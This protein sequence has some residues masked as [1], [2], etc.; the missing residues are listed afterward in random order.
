M[1]VAVDD[2]TMEKV[3]SYFFS[4]L[5][6]RMIHDSGSSLRFSKDWCLARFFLV[7]ESFSN[8]S[9][10]QV[11]VNFIGCHGTRGTCSNV[12]TVLCLKASI[13]DIIS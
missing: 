10:D 6:I 13:Y 7:K 2:L 5:M 12:G 4:P 9:K 3:R 1:T 11:K 8:L